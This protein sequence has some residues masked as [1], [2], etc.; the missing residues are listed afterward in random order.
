METLIQEVHTSLAKFVDV[1]AA[2]IAPEVDK[3][4]EEILEIWNKHNNGLL[5]SVTVEKAS[6]KPAAASAAPKKASTR[7]KASPDA[8]ICSYMF[9]KGVHNGTQCSSRVCADSTTFC[10]KHKKAQ[11]SKAAEPAGKLQKPQRLPRLRRRSEGSS[12][13]SNS[14]SS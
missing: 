11:E 7:S 8:P 2:I 13:S 4:K 10:T 1:F 5:P 9:K 14:H 12:C 3:T 6:K